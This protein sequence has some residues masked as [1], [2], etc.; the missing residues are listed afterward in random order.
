M[1]LR[2]RSSSD[3]YV[4]RLWLERSCGEGTPADWR[5]SLEDPH[6]G[7]LRGFSSL[8]DL[9]VFLEARMTDMARLYF[10]RDAAE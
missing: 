8:F 5:F 3:I 10:S 1:E 2:E 9:T 6:T 4:L 7:V